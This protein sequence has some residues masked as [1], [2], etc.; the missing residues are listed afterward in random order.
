MAQ[1]DR[2]LFLIEMQ[3]GVGLSAAPATLVDFEN[4]IGGAEK[5]E[6][7]RSMATYRVVMPDGT[8]RFSSTCGLKIREAMRRAGYT[9]TWLRPDYIPASVMVDIKTEG[10]R[11]HAVNVPTPANLPSSGDVFGL[12]W[13]RADAHVAA[14][15]SILAN[16]DGTVTVIAIEAGQ[17][18]P[19][20]RQA[21]ARK[22][23]TWTWDART[24]TY[25]D[26]SKSLT[27][28]IVDGQSARPVSWWIDMS[29]LPAG[30]PT[31]PFASTGQASSAPRGNGTPGTA[32]TG[33]QVSPGAGGAPT[34]PTLR[35]GASGD[36]V[37]NWQDIIGVTVDGAFGPATEAATKAWQAKHG[38][39]PD[40][41]VGPATWR[42]AGVGGQA[43]PTPAPATVLEG[44]DVSSIQG[45]IDWERVA[46]AGI[47]FAYVRTVIGLDTRDAMRAVNA[48]RAR[49]AGVELGMYGVCYPR[50]GR[51]QD[52]EKQ[53]A[54]LAAD[55]K[56]SGA[57]LRPMVDFE[58]LSDVPNATPQE[59]LAALDAY[60]DGLEAAG[61]S[62]IL[63]TYPS[64]WRS[65]SGWT[66]DA[67]WA[68]Y[69][70]WIAH[71]TKAAQPDVPPPWTRALVW[72]YA[73]S[74]PGF[75]GRV[76]GV[77]GLVDRNRLFGS[78]GD[79]RAR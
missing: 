77:P 37:R 53:A 3:A 42:A 18:D 68:E 21:C 59:W 15:E 5:P 79:L 73:A 50:H 16:E 75:E 40:A 34:M 1:R 66:A 69:P 60:C 4:S 14:V 41:A 11:A 78:L 31:A 6:M 67:R 28:G 51:A 39:V 2:E 44:I 24:K 54:Q 56:A 43:S 20:N 61:L 76:D 17:I 27:P 7:R 62:P 46:A 29:K 48:A 38:L 36:A 70:L 8:V 65:M 35:R 74:A 10:Q 19:Q 12:G 23:H 47:R 30:G 71:Y 13:D 63:Y 57:T 52:A 32:A 22:R 58:S 26:R 72:Q 25:T 55:H 9:A 33:P 45:V 64:F 49:K